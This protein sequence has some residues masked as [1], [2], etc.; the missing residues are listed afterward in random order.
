MD[1][2]NKCIPIISFNADKQTVLWWSK[3]L[4]E[5]IKR[6]YILSRKLNRLNQRFKK[7]NK[8]CDI[9]QTLQK[10]VSIAL[11]LECTKPCLN[12]TAALIRKNILQ[13]KKTSWKN[14]VTDFSEATT[15]QLWHKFRKINGTCLFPPRS[16]IL[17]NGHR[18]HDPKQ[19]SNIIGRHLQSVGDSLNTDAYF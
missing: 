18:I 7:I 6:K 19:I 11:E 1:A 16:P 8:K 2:S 17:H 15:K 4:S 3:E 9:T 12:K 14:Y 5:L 13:N 10:L